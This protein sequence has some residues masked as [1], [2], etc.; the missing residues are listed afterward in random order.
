MPTVCSRT[1]IGQSTHRIARVVLRPTVP[2]PATE[3]LLTAVPQPVT[4]DA[5]GDLC[6]QAAELEA[7]RQR[8]EELRRQA[9]EA[10]RAR[11]AAD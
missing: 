11:F 4:S 8:E 7:A 5:L 9:A 3:S 1:Q 6:R 2:V 10:A